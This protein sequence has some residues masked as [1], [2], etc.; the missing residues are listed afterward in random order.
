MRIAIAAIALTL[1]ACGQPTQT[2]VSGPVAVTQPEDAHAGSSDAGRIPEQPFTLESEALVGLW[3]FDRS[4]GLYD[5]VFRADGNAEYFDYTTTE[6]MAMSYGGTWAT[7]NNNR[8]VLTLRRLG[9][10]GAPAGDPV[11]YNLDVGATVTD[12]LVGR[13]ARADGAAAQD[14]TARRCPEEDRD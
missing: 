6:G 7:T 10:A 11:T 2:T 4:C 3:S 1:A 5:L 14:I 9:P 12:D 13:F 8:V